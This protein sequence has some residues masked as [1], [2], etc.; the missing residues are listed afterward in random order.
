MFG[1]WYKDAVQ[2]QYLSN[3][4]ITNITRLHTTN[5]C[6]QN[7]QSKQTKSFVDVLLIQI[8]THNI[9]MFRGFFEKYHVN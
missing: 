7:Y 5:R 1:I 2:L 3:T 9:E 4:E 6:L 8:D